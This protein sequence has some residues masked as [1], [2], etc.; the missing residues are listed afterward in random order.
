MRGYFAPAI[1]IAMITPAI[2]SARSDDIP[3][4]DV[5]PVC[6]GIATQGE[7]EEG[8]QQ[9]SFQQ[10]VKSEQEVREQIKKEWSTFRQQTRVIA[11]PW[12]R[13]EENRVTPSS[14]PVWK[15]RAMSDSCTAKLT[16]HPQPSR[17]GFRHRWV[18][19]S[20]RQ[21]PLGNS[22][23]GASLKFDGPIPTATQ[24]PHH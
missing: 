12:L 7:L 2:L 1:A 18:I 3:T 13:Q 24:S 22:G 23:G 6:H 4:L 19:A 10:C 16:T 14:S 20:R 8:L 11:F 5:N 15:W 21:H 9:T 17:R